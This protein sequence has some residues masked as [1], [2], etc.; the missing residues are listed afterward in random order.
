MVK[1]FAGKSGS[2]ESKCNF[3]SLKKYFNYAHNSPDSAKKL[4]LQLEDCEKE[5]K[6]N[7]HAIKGCIF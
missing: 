5:A 3:I 1:T 2:S 7:L 6:T 4:M